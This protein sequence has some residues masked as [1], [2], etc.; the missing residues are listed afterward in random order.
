MQCQKPPTD[1]GPPYSSQH[2]PSSQC[3]WD[4][5][6]PLEDSK[7]FRIPSHRSEIYQLNVQFIGGTNGNELVK[8]CIILGVS[9]NPV[10]LHQLC[11]RQ[12]S[13]WWWWWWW[14][15]CPSLATPPDPSSPTDWAKG[16]IDVGVAPGCGDSHHKRNHGPASIRESTWSAHGC[17]VAPVCNCT[18]SYIYIYNT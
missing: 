1:K 8:A 18:Y 7:A 9:R 4:Q 5:S 15:W 12:P 13:W 14:W 6:S 11:D 17:L 2:P 10:G 3:P 16:S